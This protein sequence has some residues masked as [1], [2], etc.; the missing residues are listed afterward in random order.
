MNIYIN[1]SRKRIEFL[2]F[3][4]D[5]GISVADVCTLLD[6]ADN[7][8]LVTFINPQAWSIARKQQDYLTALQQMTLVLP[9]GEGVAKACRALRGEQCTRLSFDMT[10]IANPFFSYAAEA[11]APVMLVGGAPG[12]GESVRCK[13]Q[14]NYPLLRIIG[15]EHGYGDFGPKV[16][17][18]LLLKPAAVIVGMGSPY[19]ENF[20]IA[21]KT[22]GYKGLAIT[23]GGFFDQYLEDEQ[24]YP[25]WIDYWNLRFAWR[26]Y[27]EPK[28]LWR[29]YLVD[30]QTMIRLVITALYK[31]HIGYNNKSIRT[32]CK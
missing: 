23:C 3:P 29:R 17:S 4:L 8:R 2:N 12:V 19:Q 18:I 22:A 11:N 24:Y 14:K 26:L 32:A 1:N 9:D 10:S 28:R 27:K 25:S 15:I 16:D 5:T 6:K 21:L 13:L 31:K 7:M 20:L 30:Y